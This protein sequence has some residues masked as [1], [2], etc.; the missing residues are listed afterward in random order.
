MRTITINHIIPAI[1]LSLFII[2]LTGQTAHAGTTYYVRT[3]GSD[4]ANGLTPETAFASIQKAVYSCSGAGNKIYVGPGSYYEQVYINGSAGN[5]TA[6]ELNRIIGDTGG[7]YTGD[8]S[9]DVI[10]EGD[11]S[12]YYGIIMQYRNYWSIESMTVQNQRYY[13]IYNTRGQGCAVRGCTIHV[14]RYYGIIFIYTRDDTIHGNRLERTSNS[15]H[16]IYAYSM[17]G[18][19]DITSNRFSLTGSDYLSQGYKNGWRGRRWRR[20][21]YGVLAY[22]FYN[23]PTT[24]VIKNNVGS[25][26]YVGI[27]CYA[28]RSG[29]SATIANNSMS[30]CLYG[31]LGYTYQGNM[32]LSDNIVTDSYYGAYMY[33]WRGNGTISGMLLEGNTCKDL[34]TYGSI[35]QTGIIIGE[36]PMWTDPAA[37][38]FL[39]AVGSPAIDSGT[40]A[41]GVGTDIRTVNRPVDGDGDS[42]AQYDMGAYEYDPSVDGEI[43]PI[44]VTWKEV[45]NQD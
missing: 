14:P 11:N 43:N 37:G 3:S 36:D 25:D 13:A 19:L 33:A 26:C 8:G 7:I 28:Y 6:S 30:G 15:G 20:Y 42:L 2:S 5:G 34:Y 35:S 27:Y 38:N 17:G 24:I 41:G 4:L 12:R 44:V 16:C 9:G 21:S 39:P 45:E 29:N 23:S 10:I 31:V 40:G 1:L 18:T 22:A 32:T